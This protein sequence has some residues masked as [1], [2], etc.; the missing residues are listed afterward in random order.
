[1]AYKCL[2]TTIFCPS[3]ISTP[4]TLSF[5][6]VEVRAAPDHVVERLVVASPD[7]DLVAVGVLDD[8][9]LVRV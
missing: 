8:P 6:V 2:Q 7:A 3:F 5:P 4:S 1:M 9:E